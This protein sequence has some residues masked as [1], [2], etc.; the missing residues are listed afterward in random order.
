MSVFGVTLVHIF[1]HLDWVQRDT[2]Y[3]SVFSP[4]A[5]KCG[6]E[7]LLIRTFFTQILAAICF[8]YGRSLKWNNWTE[9]SFEMNRKHLCPSLPDV[10]L[11]LSN[12]QLYR[13]GASVW[14]LHQLIADLSF[15]LCIIN[16]MV[17]FSIVLKEQRK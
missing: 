11:I 4:N 1:R 3:L 14:Y 12:Y 5:G 7:K 13:I 15:P 9:L 16:N 8:C 10:G 6:P 17:N 2:G